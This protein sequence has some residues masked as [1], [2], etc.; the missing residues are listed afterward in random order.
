MILPVDIATRLE[1]SKRGKSGING[2]VFGKEKRE[3]KKSQKFF[4]KE[5]EKQK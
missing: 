1:T 3:E 2:Y 5:L 4:S